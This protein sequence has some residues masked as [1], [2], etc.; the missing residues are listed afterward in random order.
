MDPVSSEIWRIYHDRS[1]STSVD[2]ALRESPGGPNGTVAT[3]TQVKACDSVDR[4]MK[5]EHSCCVSVT[6]RI[7]KPH[8]QS[9]SAGYI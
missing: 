8:Y 7:H 3:G 6:V 5:E 4:E 1:D 2:L 9:D